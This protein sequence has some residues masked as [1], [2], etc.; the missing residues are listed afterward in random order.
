MLNDLHNNLNRISGI[1]EEFP[2]DRKNIFNKVEQVWNDALLSWKHHCM[3][4]EYC[5]D[6]T[7]RPLRRELTKC[8]TVPLTQAASVMVNSDIA[9][10]NSENEKTALSVATHTTQLCSIGGN[11]ESAKCLEPIRLEDDAING[12]ANSERPDINHETGTEKNACDLETGVQKGETPY[13]TDDISGYAGGVSRTGDP[14]NERLAETSSKEKLVDQSDQDAIFA[15]LR[16]F[17]PEDDFR[18]IYSHDADQL[19]YETGTTG[20]AVEGPKPTTPVEED[21][22]SYNTPSPI[23]ASDRGQDTVADVQNDFTIRA[24]Q[25]SQVA[26]TL[27]ETTTVYSESSQ[28]NVT[29]H[30]LEVIRYTAT[31]SGNEV[32]DKLDGGDGMDRRAKEHVG[33]SGLRR[34]SLYES[35]AD[36]ERA[37]I[38][39]GPR[40]DSASH[41]TG[42]SDDEWRMASERTS[43]GAFNLDR[44]NTDTDQPPGMDTEDD[45]HSLIS[46]GPTAAAF[47]KPQQDMN[48]DGD[49][50]HA[51]R[52]RLSTSDRDTTKKTSAGSS[53]KRKSPV[54]QLRSNAK[55]AK[56]LECN[57]NFAVIPNSLLPLSDC[58]VQ[59]AEIHAK[60]SKRLNTHNTDLKLMLTRL[61]YAIGSPESFYQLK[62]ACT[63]VWNMSALSL[64]D[65]HG[66]IPPLRALDKLDVDVSVEPILRR[67]YLAELVASRDRRQAHYGAQDCRMQQPRLLRFG[68]TKPRAESAT[69][70][71]RLAT[72]QALK[73]L[74]LESYP[75]LRKVAETDPEYKSKLAILNQRLCNGRHWRTLEERYSSGILSL[76]PTGDTVCLFNSR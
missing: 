40:R 2:D 58:L 22:N 28:K 42:D 51:L 14:E 61:F 68:Y 39:D 66:S 21:A 19:L 56:I 3:Y 44:A 54:K 6:T 45:G 71:T 52:P 70:G 15:D 1:L 65:S 62:V 7:Q 38:C 31:S 59:P 29:P 26:S 13:I 32:Q 33:V 17:V 30:H 55:Q 76:I 75:N 43:I 46:P 50:H 57:A 53:K 49:Q 12:R 25:Y 10:S 72:R 74:L 63:G 18:D 11:S 16:P 8:N 37:S 48:P 9:V 73:D 35:M 5:R 60:I 34:D 64:S 47:S 41:M 23:P 27:G 69:R 20:T 4:N 67:Y 36:E 24:S